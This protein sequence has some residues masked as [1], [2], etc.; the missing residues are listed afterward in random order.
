M[1]SVNDE[2]A[3][4]TGQGSAANRTAFHAAIR[5]SAGTAMTVYIGEI[6]PAQPSDVS[7]PVRL[8][9]AGF[10]V[11]GGDEPRSK[12]GDDYPVVIARMKLFS[13][14][15]AKPAALRGAKAP[16]TSEPMTKAITALAW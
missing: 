11:S 14:G 5:T 2:A 13:A 9:L 15:A 7:D 10:F 1:R 3:R 12:N 6:A 16:N 4:T 8:C